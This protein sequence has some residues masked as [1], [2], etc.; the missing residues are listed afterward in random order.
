MLTND[1]GTAIAKQFVIVKQASGYGVFDGKH[2]DNVA[3]LFHVVED[4]FKRVATYQFDFFVGEE[5]MGGNIMKRPGYS[6]NGYLLHSSIK[7]K[8]P[9]FS[10]GFIV[11]IK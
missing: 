11:Y 8:N 7:I 4:F 2:P 5:L 9:A 6:L 10:A 1:G 3:I